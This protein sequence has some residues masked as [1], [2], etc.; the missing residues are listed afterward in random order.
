MNPKCI[1]NPVEVGDK[2]ELIEEPYVRKLSAYDPLHW[3]NTEP[4]SECLRPPISRSRR[5]PHGRAVRS[6]FSL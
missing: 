5:F 6:A 1:K 3:T 4:L 2:K